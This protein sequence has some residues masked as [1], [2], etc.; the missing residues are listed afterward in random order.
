MS[1]D[2]LYIRFLVGLFLDVDR[3]NV[4]C[5]DLLSF[6]LLIVDG[7]GVIVSINIY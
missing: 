2:T 3:L 6:V 5:L 1:L 4:Y 7:F